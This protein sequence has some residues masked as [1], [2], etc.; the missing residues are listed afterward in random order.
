[1][2]AFDRDLKRIEA[3]FKPE[4]Q[5]ESKSRSWFAAAAIA[6]ARTVLILFAVGAA[7]GAAL[8]YLGT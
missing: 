2:I 3:Y 5:P 8:R 1:M 6:T 4:Q 7:T